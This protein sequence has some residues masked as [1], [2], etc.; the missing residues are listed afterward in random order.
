MP[1]IARSIP[2]FQ[3]VAKEHALYFDDLSPSSLA[4]TVKEWLVLN[5]NGDVPSSHD[6]PWLTWKQSTADLIALMG[7]ALAE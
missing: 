5:K 1:I 4:E 3:E 7:L 2:V 6:L